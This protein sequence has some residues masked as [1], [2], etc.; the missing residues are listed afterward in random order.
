MTTPSAAARASLAGAAPHPF[1]LDTPSRP[2]AL[3]ALGGAHT[4]D[5]AVV[6]GGYAGL[7]TALIAKERD[8]S[9]RVV[10]LEGNRIAWAAS[11][12]NGGFCAASL[13]HGTANGRQHFPDEVD[14]LDR[15]GLEN[16]DELEQTVAQYGI[17]CDF[18][19]TGGIDV[20]TAPH[21][22]DWLREE[23]DEAHGIRFLDQDQMR[24]EVDSPT[25]LA[26][27]WDTR[28]TALVHPAK[29][30][31]G[32]RDACLEAGVEIFEHTPVRG[33]ASDRTGVTLKTDGGS[34]RAA[35]AAL[36]TNVFPSLL[37]RT[38]LH[39]VPVYDY[40]LMTEPLSAAQRDAIGWKNR[41]G[42]GDVSNLFHYYRQTADHRILF[43]GY[44]AVYHFGRQVK[45]EYDQ[46]PATFEKL[47]E[48][49]FETFPQLEGLRFSHQWGGAIDTCSRF[50]SF[51]TTAHRGRVAYSAGYTGLGVGATRFGAKVMLDLLSGESTELTNLQMVRR[52][53]LPFP[54]EP[55]A[56][57]GIKLTTRELI[58]ADRNHG[59]RGLWL[60]ALDRAGVGFDS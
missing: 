22:V 45:L 4:T 17:D 55:L 58:R 15:L 44:D 27:L 12:R 1:W 26:G 9:R 53:P 19:R 43:G 54:P 56:W 5:L 49:F 10:L 50:F 60:K 29:L 51:F 23:A 42:L 37:R 57:A 52:L 36:A 11:G 21:Q 16:L 20:A 32:L 18:E 24:A 3:P 25:Y 13:T 34:V 28:G 2:D 35:R 59:E 6:G 31:W 30:A 39:T 48:H 14:T 41:Q 7:W 47:A 8:P 46:R 33:L 38:R 40:A